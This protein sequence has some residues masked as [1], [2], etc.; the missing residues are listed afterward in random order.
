MKLPS[1]PIVEQ[2]GRLCCS[3]NWMAV[4]FASSLWLNCCRAILIIDG[5]SCDVDFFQ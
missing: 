3:G 4:G 2:V 5:C 1:L